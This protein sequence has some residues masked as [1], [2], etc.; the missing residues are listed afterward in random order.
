MGH[1]HIAALF[2]QRDA[3]KI[4]PSP[5][6][7][8]VED[9]ETGDGGFLLTLIESTTTVQSDI[10]SD[11]GSEDATP[12]SLSSQQPSPRSYDAHFLPYDPGERIPIARHNTNDQDDVRRGYIL[13]GTCQ[14]CEHDF[15]TRKIKKKNRRF[16]LVW[17]YKYPW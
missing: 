11:I 17:F 10:E 2:L 4:A 7:L 15:P 16:T 8:V 6:P 9:E 13:K 3:K 14:P 5:L 1:S 12:H